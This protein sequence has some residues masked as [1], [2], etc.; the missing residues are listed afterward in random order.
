MKRKLLYL[1]LSFAVLMVWGCGI[2]YGQYIKLNYTS[3]SVRMS[4]ASVTKQDILTALEYEAIKGTKDIPLITAWIQIDNQRFEYPELA[5]SVNL[6][7]IEFWGDI[8][9]IM[10]LQL[11]TGSIITPED[12]TGCVIDE[13]A[14]YQLFRTKDAV[15]R[16]ITYQDQSYCIRGVVRTK[17]KVVIIPVPEAENTYSNL[18][19]VY[20]NKERGEQN[21]QDFMQQNTQVEDYTIVEGCFYARLIQMLSVLPPWLLGF[22]IL[23]QLA[24]EC[25]KRRRQRKQVAF[26]MISFCIVL[27]L[28]S[29]MIE[30]RIALPERWI[31]TRWSDFTFWMER[32]QELVKQLEKLEYLEPVTKDILLFQAL[33]RCATFHIIT[34]V[35]AVIL[36]THRKV[37]LIKGQGMK[38][39]LIVICLEGIATFCLYRMGMEFDLTRAYLCILPCYI[40][41]QVDGELVLTLA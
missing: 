23:Y 32:W 3:V 2:Y 40:I 34:L 16:Y 36:V 26:L 39:S 10:P 30:F 1:L 13:N 28:L 35:A 20:A 22:A 5:T 19:F 33:R 14:A 24:K 27:L 9:Q 25:W 8:N 37:F 15:G 17:E 7:V 12:N 21:A 11:L 18:E 41:A 6:S 29:W 38:I 4:E 31:P